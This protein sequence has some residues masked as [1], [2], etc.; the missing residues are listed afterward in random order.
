[1][2]TKTV[3]STENYWV[4]QATG[5][6]SD[7]EVKIRATHE[8]DGVVRLGATAGRLMGYAIY[9]T[10]TPQDA[11]SLAQWLLAITAGATAA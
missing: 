10:L 4:G 6:A 11:R 1:M 2:R 9:G 3:L 7:P 5:E 8:G